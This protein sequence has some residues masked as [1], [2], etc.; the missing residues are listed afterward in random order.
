MDLKNTDKKYSIVSK[1]NKQRR[2]IDLF[3]DLGDGVKIKYIR[4][5][6]DEAEV[7]RISSEIKDLLESGY[8]K[9]DIAIF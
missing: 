2:D 5:Y 4:A 1:N 6:N 9:K 8:Q 3:S 7:M